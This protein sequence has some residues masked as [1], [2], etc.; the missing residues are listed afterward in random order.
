MLEI[1][2]FFLEDKYAL[3]EYKNEF[4]ENNEV[5]HGASS[6]NQSDCEIWIKNL[7]LFKNK[8]T[9]PNNFVTATTFGLFDDKKLL[10]II[11][12]RHSLND[13]LYNFGGHIGYSVRKTERKKGYAI[14]MLEYCINFANNN[15]KLEKVLL[16]CDSKNIASKKT[17]IKCG[18]I[19]ENKVVENDRITERYWI[20]NNL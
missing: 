12:I 15:L 11:N 10:G 19:L 8:D 14:K 6:L 4:L 16:T 9:T 20:Y 13:Y 17:I 2:E 5:I 1:R 18:G 7:E 3:Q